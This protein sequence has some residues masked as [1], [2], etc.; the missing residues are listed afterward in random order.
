MSIKNY[1]RHGIENLQ[2]DHVKP[3]DRLKIPAWVLWGTLFI[4]FVEI[5]KQK[6]QNE[7]M[8]I[9]RVTRKNMLLAMK[10]T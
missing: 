5:S 7:D 2:H 8:D 9:E 4:F 1:D 6:L 3:L 10:R